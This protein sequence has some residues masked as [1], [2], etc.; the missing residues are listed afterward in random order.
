MATMKGLR[1]QLAS[2]YLHLREKPAAEAKRKADQLRIDWRESYDYNPQ[3]IHHR[4]Q[5]KKR[6]L[7]RRR[8]LHV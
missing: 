6:I 4:S 7:A 2:L 5:K 8:N 1:D 3:L